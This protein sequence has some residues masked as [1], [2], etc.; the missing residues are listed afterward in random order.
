MIASP[1]LNSTPTPT[2]SNPGSTSS[3]CAHWIGKSP[4]QWGEWDGQPGS[5]NNFVY[6]VWQ[7]SDCC[8]GVLG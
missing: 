5:G 4:L 2:A 6:L 8:M 1:G 3:K 7:W